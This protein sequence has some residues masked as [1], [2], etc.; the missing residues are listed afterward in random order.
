MNDDQNSQDDSIIQGIKEN[1]QN[2]RLA[3]FARSTVLARTA[4]LQQ[5]RDVNQYENNSENK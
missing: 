4:T 1:N 5:R 2:P 3:G